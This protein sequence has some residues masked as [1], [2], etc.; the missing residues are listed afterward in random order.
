MIKCH[1]STITNNM[2]L[3]GNEMTTGGSVIILI[4]VSTDETTMSSTRNGNAMRNPI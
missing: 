3:R 1:P 4:D 2:S